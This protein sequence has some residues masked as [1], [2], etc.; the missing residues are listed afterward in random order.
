MSPDLILDRAG[1]AAIPGFGGAALTLRLE[2][3]LPHPGDATARTLAVVQDAHGGE[4]LGVALRRSGADM[5][6]R[7]WDDQRE[8]LPRFADA[9]GTTAVLEAV[10]SVAVLPPMRATLPSRPCVG[11]P[12][13]LLGPGRHVVEVRVHAARLDLLVDGRLVDEEWTCGALAAEPSRLHLC[14]GTA[15]VWRGTCDDG[16]DHGGESAGTIAGHQLQYW[17]PSGHNRWAGDTML[18]HDGQRLHLM[19][20]I[21]RRHHGSKG[22][23]GA[24]QV[25]HLSTTDLRSW[26]SHPLVVGVDEPWEAIGTGSLVRHQD[27]WHFIYG[28]HSGRCVT[29]ASAGADLPQPFAAIDGTP[30]GTAIAISDDGVHFRKQAVLVHAA[31]N[32]S[33]F[34]DPDGGFVMFAGEGAYGLYRSDDLQHWRAVDHCVVPYGPAS[35]W[36]N[37]CECMCHLEWGGWHYLWGGFTG[38]WMSRSIAGPY[39][40]QDGAGGAAAV[41]DIAAQHG[42]AL[43]NPR[44]AGQP[45]RPRHDIYDGLSAPMAATMPDGRRVLCG[46]LLGLRGW[47]GRLVLRELLQE[48]DGTLGMRWLPEAVP[49][50]GAAVDL[51]WDRDPH[52]AAGEVATVDGL[53]EAWLLECEVV[54]RGV[55]VSVLV[56]GSG[57]LVD[58]VELRVD[59]VRGVAQWGGPRGGKPAPDLR[60]QM[61]ELAVMPRGQHPYDRPSPHLA[62]KAGDFAIDGVR[63]IDRPYRLRLIVLRDP[64]TGGVILDAEI[65]GCRTLITRRDAQP[66]RRLQLMAHGDAAFRDLSVRSLV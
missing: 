1:D 66:G 63:G 55:A 22:Q 48:A 42:A 43:L 20:L 27:R 59:P 50:V 52:L 60:G 64:A 38:F 28:L 24:H 62:C 15:Q 31:Q 4:L 17:K 56:G 40:D 11:V 5:A 23:C 30:E 36:R 10:C 13:V 44:P 35:P 49:Q 57:C 39:W 58:G 51:H 19:Y 34:P 6:R 37:T 16:A 21:D 8:N 33:V 53:P 46:W 61:A 41:A 2:I 12:L 45:G 32:P 18:C 65:A 9:S 47:G 54:A 7:Q 29:D 26:T 25:A 3:D 14:H